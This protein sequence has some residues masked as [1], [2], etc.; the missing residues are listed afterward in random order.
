M[1]V[2]VIVSCRNYKKAVKCCDATTS[3]AFKL[4]IMTQLYLNT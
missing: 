1:D 3:P 4:Y 2:N